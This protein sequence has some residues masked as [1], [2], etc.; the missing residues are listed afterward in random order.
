VAVEEFF[1]NRFF[2]VHQLAAAGPAGWRQPSGRVFGF[3]FRVRPF[4]AC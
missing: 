2:C 4:C 1:F 3:C